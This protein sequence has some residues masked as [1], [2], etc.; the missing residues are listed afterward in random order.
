MVIKERR[1][2]KKIAVQKMNYEN[3]YYHRCYTEKTT[4]L[5]LLPKIK[6][7]QPATFSQHNLYVL[8]TVFKRDRIQFSG[9]AYIF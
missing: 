2:R 1:I 4:T 8:S 5:F 3:D 6:Y 7:K 9:T